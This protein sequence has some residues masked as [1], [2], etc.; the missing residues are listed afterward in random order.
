MSKQTY[1]GEGAKESIPPS[2]TEAR[3]FDEKPPL[4]AYEQNKISNAITGPIQQHQPKHPITNNIN[5]TNYGKP[6]NKQT[7]KHTH[8]HT[9]NKEA[10]VKLR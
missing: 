8:T 7:K 6:T 4:S 1:N 10:V 9:Q 2:D 5:Q 3:L